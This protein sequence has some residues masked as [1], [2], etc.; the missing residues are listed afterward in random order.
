MQSWCLLYS[1]LSSRFVYPPQAREIV[2]RC[3]CV[4][5]FNPC[6]LRLPC[7]PRLPCE[8]HVNEERSEFHRGSFGKWYWG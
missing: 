5:S 2:M 4:R 3:L 7:L 1:L 8:I 6:N